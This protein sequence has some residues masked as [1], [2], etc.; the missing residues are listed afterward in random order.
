MFI[1]L[2]R[3]AVSLHSWYVTAAEDICDLIRKSGCWHLLNTQKFE[4]SVTFTNGFPNFSEFSWIQFGLVHCYLYS[5]TTTVASRHFLY[6]ISY[7]LINCYN[8]TI[9]ISPYEQALGNS[10]KQK[11][12]FNR[13]KHLAQT[14]SGRG[15]HMCGELMVRGKKRAEWREAIVGEIWSLFLVPVSVLK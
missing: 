13:K 15:S 12:P 11:R 7:Y 1:Q 3:K 8:P 9:S 6:Y 2:P 14:G 4:L 5:I 10:G